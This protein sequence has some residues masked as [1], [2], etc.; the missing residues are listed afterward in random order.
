MRVMTVPNANMAAHLEDAC[1]R[2]ANNFGDESRFDITIADEVMGEVIDEYA[3]WVASNDSEPYLPKLLSARIFLLSNW[4]VIN[5]E[6]LTIISDDSD[7]SEGTHKAQLT[8]LYK[9][10]K[11][12]ML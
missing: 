7:V 9:K 6:L 2:I 5:N 11:G 12:L 3:E 10:M 4:D 1:D 8:N